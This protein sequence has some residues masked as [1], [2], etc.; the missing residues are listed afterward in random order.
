[1]KNLFWCSGGNN[2]NSTVQHTHTHATHKIKVFAA[3]WATKRVIGKSLRK[4]CLFNG[5]N[6]FYMLS[7]A[8]PLLKEYITQ[9]TEQGIYSIS[10]F[11]LS[12]VETM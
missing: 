1:M 2:L 5:E 6:V 11:P 8:P 7:L 3:I 4:Q 9:S 12:H 10:R